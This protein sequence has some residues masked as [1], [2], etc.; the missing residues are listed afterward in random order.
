ME[1]KDQSAAPSGNSSRHAAIAASAASP[2]AGCPSLP[3]WPPDKPFSHPIR[4]SQFYLHACGQ[5]IPSCAVVPICRS[6]LTLSLGYPWPGS[7]W[8]GQDPAQS[9]E[10]ASAELGSGFLFPLSPVPV[11]LFRSLGNQHTKLTLPRTLQ[12]CVSFQP[13][14]AAIRW[15]DC[16]VRRRTESTIHR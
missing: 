10:S 6:G 5:R 12:R 11:P 4:L 3:L 16:S 15:I 13:P 1:R 8:L 2:N 9:L 7:S 14:Q